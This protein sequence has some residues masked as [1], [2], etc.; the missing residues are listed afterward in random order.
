[1]TGEPSLSALSQIPLHRLSDASA[2]LLSSFFFNARHYI[3][4]FPYIYR[5]R[6]YLPVPDG[7][8]VAVT[9]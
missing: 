7:W 6:E 4:P 8:P 9:I 1:M 5:R 2:S 3:H